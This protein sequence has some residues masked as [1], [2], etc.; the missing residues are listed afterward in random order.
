M[1]R[2]AKSVA[3]W[4]LFKAAEAGKA[5]KGDLSKRKAHEMLEGQASPKGLP[6]KLTGQARRPR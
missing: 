5:R 4:K 6:K 1:P 2:K 3:Q